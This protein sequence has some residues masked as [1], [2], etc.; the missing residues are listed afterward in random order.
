MVA[1]GAW[2]VGAIVALVVKVL[3]NATKDVLNVVDMTCDVTTVVA[4]IRSVAV[5]V[6]TFVAIAG[7][8][9]VGD[10]G[11]V[12]AGVTLASDGRKTVGVVLERGTITG[13]TIWPSGPVI[14]KKVTALVTP[15]SGM[16]V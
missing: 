3:V 7:V 2:A 4:V 1:A 11:T 10:A 15:S 9:V 14:G 16:V 13:V 8:T 6:A 5:V 12:G